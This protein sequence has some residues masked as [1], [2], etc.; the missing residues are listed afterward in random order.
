[1]SSQKHLLGPLSPLFFFSLLLGLSWALVNG[2]RGFVYGSLGLLIMA[3]G[4]GPWD[5]AEE[6]LQPSAAVAWAFDLGPGHWPLGRLGGAAS[7]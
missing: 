3:Q 2:P 7:Q 1:M 6:G 5:W 4:W